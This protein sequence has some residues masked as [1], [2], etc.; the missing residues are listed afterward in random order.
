MNGQG[1]WGSAQVLLVR[2]FARMRDILGDLQI[3]VQGLVIGLAAAPLVATV[4]LMLTVALNLLQ[5][6][7]V[8]LNKLLVDLLATGAIRQPAGVTEAVTLAILYSVTL[9]VPAVLERVQQ[10]LAATLRDC[11]QGEVDRRLMNAGTRLVDLGRLDRPA[12]QDEIRHLQDNAWRFSGQATAIQQSIGNIITLGGLLLLLGRLNPL[13]PLALV[14]LRL[15][16]L[17]AERSLNRLRY[18]ALAQRSHAAREMDYCAAITTEPSAAKELRVFDLGAFFL[19]RFR[20]RCAAAL[21][22]DDRLVRRKLRLVV[23]SGGLYALVLACGFWYVATQAGAARLTLGDIALYLA[24]VA[25]AENRAGLLARW[26]SESHETLL[27][28][29]GLFA[30]LDTA[31]PTIAVPTEGHSRLVPAV[32]HSGV[33]LCHVTF[34]YPEG[35]EPLLTDVCAVLRVGKVTA[36]IGANGAGKSTLA[37]LL[38]RMYDP[39]GGDILL[40]G[41]PIATYD[42]ESLRSCIAAVYQ[43]FAHFALTLRENIAVGATVP[44]D[45]AHR[46]EEAARRA[47]ADGVAARL[48]R[49]YDTELTHRFEGGVDLSGGEWQKIAL[50]RSFMRDAAL[51]ILDEPTAALDADAE[52]QLFEQFREIAVGKIALL[53]TH[54]FST[55]RMADQIIV[56]EGGRIVEAGTHNELVAKDGR[57]AT[58]YELQAGRYR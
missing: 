41:L 22:D 29:R 19:Q 33:E 34:G 23:I 9:A 45:V 13:L 15:P 12:V 16:A 2:G 30:F 26:F 20:E 1:R 48:S 31:G 4:Y 53:I 17:Q 51:V 39:T 8:W 57:Y 37:K 52:Y 36:L 50:A 38:T 7:Q 25:Q 58:L 43:D 32:L 14:I 10:P 44:E 46:V 5:V 35:M 3:W 24:A 40:N 42:L 55:T 54:R 47:G 49:G 11:A 56:L 28:L 18:Q 6:L 21:L 27:H